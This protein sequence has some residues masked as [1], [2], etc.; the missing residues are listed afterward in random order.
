MQEKQ[1]KLSQLND[2]IRERSNYLKQIESQIEIVSETGNNKLFNLNGE[3]DRA[4][5]QLASIL[6][7]SYEIDQ[8][9]RAKSSKT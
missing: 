9:N 3:I 2:Q 6:R 5:K 8:K 7:R 4:E 1:Q